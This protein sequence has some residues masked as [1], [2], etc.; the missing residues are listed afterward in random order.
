MKYTTLKEHE[1][2]SLIIKCLDKYFTDSPYVK[3]IEY[4]TLTD[5]MQFWGVCKQTASRRLMKAVKAGNIKRIAIGRPYKYLKDD[6]VNYMSSNILS[7]IDCHE[8]EK[9]ILQDELGITK[10]IN[11]D[12]EF[13]LSLIK[14]GKKQCS[15]CGEIY[16]PSDQPNTTGARCFDCYRA[17]KSAVNWFGR[18]GIKARDIDPTDLMWKIAELKIRKSIKD[19]N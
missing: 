14:E 5:V 10:K 13:K 15:E 17:K 6:V 1:I 8:Q 16:K 11:A 18:L 3:K 19:V 2:E 7:H 9:I 4:M 12:V